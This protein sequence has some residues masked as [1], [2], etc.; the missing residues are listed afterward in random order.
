MR[1]LKKNV[2]SSVWII[3]MVLL[4]VFWIMHISG[5]YLIINKGMK[6]YFFPMQKILKNQIILPLN[7]NTKPGV[8]INPCF[9]F[10]AYYH[11]FKGSGFPLLWGYLSPVAS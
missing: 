10:W 1:N 2:L 4:F 8:Q 9:H 6:K 7:I 5:F 11:V 3:V